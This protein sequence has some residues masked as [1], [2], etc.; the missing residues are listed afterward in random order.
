MTPY[1]L[2]KSENG[3]Y[4]IFLDHLANFCCVQNTNASLLMISLKL[5]PALV[6]RQLVYIVNIP[7]AF[8]HYLLDISSISFKVLYFMLIK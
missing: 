5:L 2:G 3:V 4:W 6:A 1:A 8:L 7:K